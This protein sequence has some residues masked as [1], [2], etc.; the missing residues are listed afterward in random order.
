MVSD[1]VY[2]CLDTK[3]RKL[4]T[5]VGCSDLLLLYISLPND[6]LGHLSICHLFL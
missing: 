4:P 1:L 5:V 6:T 3:F 2:I